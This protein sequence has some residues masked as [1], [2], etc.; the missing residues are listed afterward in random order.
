MRDSVNPFNVPAD[1]PIVAGYVNGH[2]AWSQAGWDRFPGAYRH[3]GIDVFGTAPHVAGILDVEK[4]DATP[5]IAVE[6][7]KARAAI[8]PSYPP[9]IYCDRSTMPT[10]IK[11]QKDAGHILGKD[12]KLW[13]ATL[14]GTQK[15]DDMT[16]VIAIQY[17]DFGGYDESIVYDDAWHEAPQPVKPPTPTPTPTPI[18][19]EQ[20]IQAFATVIEPVIWNAIAVKLKKVFEDAVSGL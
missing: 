2:Y 20:E 16:G 4:F 17:K 1:T 8:H 19:T 18:L 13:I 5:A 10:V 12:Y 11:T 9:V 15:L 6:W 14:D 3:A 7:V